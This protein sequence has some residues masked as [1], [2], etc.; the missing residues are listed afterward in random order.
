M[1]DLLTITIETL[2]QKYLILFAYQIQL[3]SK[4]NLKYVL[5]NI[6]WLDTRA[7]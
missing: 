5:T 2:L 3:L 4:K 7:S 6:V 1:V